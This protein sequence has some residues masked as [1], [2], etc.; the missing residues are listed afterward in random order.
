MID[1]LYIVHPVAVCWD[2][3]GRLLQGTG[4]NQ[5]LWGEPVAADHFRRPMSE[6]GSLAN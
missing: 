3:R 6:C 5:V 2:D 4:N 1:R